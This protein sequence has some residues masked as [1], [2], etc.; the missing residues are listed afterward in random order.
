VAKLGFTCPCGQEHKFD[1][2]ALA[3]QHI[4]ITH[5]CTCGRTNTLLQGEVVQS[6]A[7][8]S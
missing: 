8:K 1:G 5:V 3:H 7:K 2:W 6:K 4:R